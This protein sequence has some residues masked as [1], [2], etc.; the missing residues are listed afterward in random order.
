MEQG[1]QCDGV[2]H[3]VWGWWATQHLP[4]ETHS[5]SHSLQLEPRCNCKHVVRLLHRSPSWSQ[6]LIVLYCSTSVELFA[7]AVGSPQTSH[8]VPCV[9]KKVTK[10][11]VMKQLVGRRWNIGGSKGKKKKA[12]S[13]GWPS[14]PSPLWPPR[15]AP[16]SSAAACGS[17]VEET[18]GGGRQTNRN[19]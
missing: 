7:T 19:N 16:F 14:H 8:Q 3:C 15:E 12:L 4:T 5:Q 9:Q 13:G 17:R 11:Q 6:I 18:L 2:W 10:W 1:G